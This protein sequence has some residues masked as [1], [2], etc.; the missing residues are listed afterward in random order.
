MT[1]A[2]CYQPILRDIIMY[3][4]GAHVDLVQLI[5][6]ARGVA[7]QI[8][9]EVPLL[10]Q[11][12]YAARWPAF[13]DCLCHHNATDWHGLYQSTLL[14]RCE[15][16]LEIFDREKKLGF[17]MGAMPA[18]V[19]Y[20]R[21]AKGYVARYLS[22]AAVTPEAIPETEGFRLRFCPPSA[23]ER[24]LSRAPGDTHREWS[25]I[26]QMEEAEDRGPVKPVPTAYP[27]RPLVGFEGLKVGEGVELQWKMQMGSPFG[28][29][30]GVLEAL[31]IDPGEKEGSATV[32]F[33]H[34]A[35]NTRWYRLVV[36]FGSSATRPC[37]FGGYTGGIRAATEAESAH[38][39]R[40]MPKE[41]VSF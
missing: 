37:Q 4:V 34:F 11:Q 19:Q 28:W 10:W 25:D 5:R 24:L 26:Y 39:M 20:D 12:L 17:A 38:W 27:Y 40:F 23:R 41:P 22:A 7:D 8:Q 15:C 3:A 1:I 16:T 31:H 30:Y 14:G 2:D 9:N 36:R 18:R 13:H 32:I 29:W 35:S 21:S 6:S 33:K